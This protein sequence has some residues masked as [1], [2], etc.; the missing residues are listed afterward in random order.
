MVRT[1]EF[2]KTGNQMVLAQGG[3]LAFLQII[4]SQTCAEGILTSP[5]DNESVVLNYHRQ[6]K[7]LTKH[8]N[9]TL[10]WVPG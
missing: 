9:I 10:G 1:L 8:L 7:Q 2:G 6:V 5:N 3:P 4:A